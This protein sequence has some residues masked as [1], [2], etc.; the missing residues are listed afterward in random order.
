[1]YII[2]GPASL[3]RIGRRWTT[4]VADRQSISAPVIV[5]LEPQQTNHLV[6]DYKEL[7]TFIEEVG[8]RGVFYEG[9]DEI[10]EPLKLPEVFTVALDM[11]VLQE[12][13]TA[14]SSW[15]FRYPDAIPLVEDWRVL[16]SSPSGSRVRSCASLAY[17]LWMHFW[18]R[19]TLEGEAERPAIHLFN[20]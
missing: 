13:E 2:I 18:V 6:L 16:D 14:L 5:G 3:I 19:F 20:E 1:M 7:Y 12:I 17:L 8:L 15:R 11:Q 10:D 9:D 4:F